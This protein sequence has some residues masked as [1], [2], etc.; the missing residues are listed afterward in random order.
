[1][2]TC[3]YCG[4]IITARYK[5]TYCS[6]ECGAKAKYAKLKE[7]QREK[8]R[9]SRELTAK[10]RLEEKLNKKQRIPEKFLVRGEVS[11]STTISMIS[12]SA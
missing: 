2:K 6:D 9:K 4:E 5:R 10:R 11:T 12:N 8:S 1:M 7:R 3:K